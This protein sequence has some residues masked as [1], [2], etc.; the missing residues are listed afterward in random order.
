LPDGARLTLDSFT[1]ERYDDGRPKDWTSRVSVARD[2]KTIVAAFPLRVNHP[3]A[4]G[5]VTLYQASQETR[6]LLKLGGSGTSVATLAIGDSA[7]VSGRKVTFEALGSEGALVSV[8]GPGKSLEYVLK[9]GDS[10]GDIAVQALRQEEVSGI[11]LVR[12]SFFGLI[13]LSL[14]IVAIGLAI[15]FIQKLGEIST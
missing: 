12:D 11:M 5:N 1:A 15:T 2:G 14:A 13:L 3:L 10:V 8:S 4:I 6:A 7:S 9:P